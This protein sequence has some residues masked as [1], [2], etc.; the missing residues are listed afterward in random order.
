MTAVQHHA[1]LHEKAVQ[2]VATN[3]LALPPRSRRKPRRQD[4][5]VERAPV[6]AMVV[7]ALLAEGDMSRVQVERG[8]TVLVRNK[9]RPR[10]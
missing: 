1:S 7:A 3:E 8:G 5:S 9:R 10:P 4:M 2:R 6:L